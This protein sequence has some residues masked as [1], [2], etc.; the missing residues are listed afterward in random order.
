[1][2][3]YIKYKLLLTECRLLIVTYLYQNN[4]PSTECKAST[5]ISNSSM[6]HLR[7]G[8][9]YSNYTQLITALLTTHSIK[10]HS[11]LYC[12]SYNL[13]RSRRSENQQQESRR[14]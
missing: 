7:H 11:A 3:S 13:E 12:P 10:L 14:N 9:H 1:M 6:N 8:L 5:S 4:N 2:N